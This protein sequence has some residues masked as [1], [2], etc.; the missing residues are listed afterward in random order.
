MDG[1]CQFV[2]ERYCCN[3]NSAAATI[4][5]PRRLFIATK[6]REAGILAY[7]DIY[8]KFGNVSRQQLKNDQLSLK[9]AGIAIECTVEGRSGYFFDPQGHHLATFS[10]RRVYH[11]KQKRRIAFIAAYLAMTKDLEETA[12]FE[13]SFRRRLVLGDEE[14]KT[15]LLEKIFLVS[16]SRHRSAFLDG[17]TTT[18]QVAESFVDFNPLRKP[19]SRITGMDVWT[20]N[21]HIMERLN[22]LVRFNLGII[23]GRQI[24][25]TAAFAGTEAVQFVQEIMP[26]M[27]MCFIGASYIMGNDIY[28][29]NQAEAE[30]KRAVIDKSKIVIIVADST[31]FES[32]S[33]QEATPTPELQSSHMIT[34]L[35]PDTKAH[36]L[37]T[38]SKPDLENVSLPIYCVDFPVS[39]AIPS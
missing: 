4:D 7:S 5:N 1:Y 35:G 34:S 24:K 12:G 29:G 6:I 27:D 38:N 17:G 23:G 21:Q 9:R 14:K 10:F 16:K 30:L 3:M 22:E 2:H 26:K 15:S 25:R 18:Y 31:K 37:I 32:D 19:Y 36:L 33:V 20:N 11:A 8:S 13:H 28:V 39:S